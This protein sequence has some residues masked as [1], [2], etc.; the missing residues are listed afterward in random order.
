MNVVIAEALYKRCG[1][2]HKPIDL[3]CQFFGS[4]GAGMR[5]DD[6]GDQFYGQWRAA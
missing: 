6:I 2:P 4:A 5:F 3:L 1:V